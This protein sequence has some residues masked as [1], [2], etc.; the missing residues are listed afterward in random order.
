MAK[1]GA[2][3][4]TIGRRGDG[5]WR[6]LLMVGTKPDGSP[7][8]RAV[9]GKTR[10][11]VQAK[12][13]A[14]RK[15]KSDGTLGEPSK[16]RVTVASF[17]ESWLEAT[18]STIRLKTYHR[19]ESAVRVHLTPALG[20]LKLSDLRGDRLQRLY[21]EKL[22][23]GLSPRSVVHIHRILHRALAQGVRW[24]YC[25]VNVCELVDPPKVPRHEMQTFT[26]EHARAFLAA[27]EGDPLE[28]LY[29]LALTTGMRQGELRG[30]KWADLDLDAA[31]VQVRRTLGR[32][33][34][35]GFVETEPKS[36]QS[37]RRIDLD[38]LA[39]RA[40]RKHRTGQL[41]QRL[42][43]G[44]LWSD[45]D[46]V[47]CTAIGTPIEHGNLIRRS[48]E[49]LMKRAGVP[50]IRFHDLRHTFA[51][52]MLADEQHPKVVQEM[53]GHSQISLTL[54]TYSHVTPSLKRDAAHRLGR[55]LD[56]EARTG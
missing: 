11:L 23:G 27:A 6:G 30:L 20:K 18:K 37:R 32:I 36:R 54:D 17:L 5:M 55:M 16:E 39:V 47:F 24:G 2:G 38:D 12:L 40:L 4:G 56:P 33:K 35:Q 42:T 21:S 52:L 48:F 49:P 26:L 15:R 46:Y 25:A 51:S 19:Y 3:E 50:R 31:T 45:S 53:L 13:D 10:A 44:P 1:R 9:Y 41:E 14:L 28:A 43:A 7:D 8:R 29:V 34:G 22:A